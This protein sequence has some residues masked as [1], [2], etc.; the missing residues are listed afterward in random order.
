M[1]PW[2]W[3]L[4]VNSINCCCPDLPPEIF[5]NIPV[6]LT[7]SLILIEDIE[8]MD[9]LTLHENMLFI[10]LATGS[11]SLQTLTQTSKSLSIDCAVKK[12]FYLEINTF[13]FIYFRICLKEILN[14]KCKS[15]YFLPRFYFKVYA[16]DSTWWNISLGVTC[17]VLPI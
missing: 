7:M 4:S 8:D 17:V 5:F 11:R 16:S 2:L 3:L 6:G 9:W 10:L 1:F 15:I 14:V 13:C 12:Q